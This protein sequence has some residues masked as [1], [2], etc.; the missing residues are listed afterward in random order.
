MHNKVFAII[1][2]SVVTN[3]VEVAEGSTWLPS[4]GKLV[5][6][7]EGIH[8]I[9]LGTQCTDDTFIVQPDPEIDRPAQFSQARANAEMWDAT[10]FEQKV[11]AFLVKVGLLDVDPTKIKVTNL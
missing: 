6:L 3:I 2:N 11:A 5:P 9:K 10:M 7:P 4:S 8:N 1:E